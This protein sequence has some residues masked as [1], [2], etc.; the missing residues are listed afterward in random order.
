VSSNKTPVALFTYNRPAEAQ[1]VLQT[2]SKCARLDECRVFIYCD[3]PASAETR[4]RVEASRRV[5]R[6]WAGP[7]KAEVIERDE[8]LGLARS[9]VT[10]VTELCREMGRV[11]VVEDDFA[12][13]PDFL[14]YMLDGLAHYRDAPEVYQISGYMFPV[15][16]SALPELFFLPLTTTWGWATWER[17]WRI[18]DWDAT[19]ALSQLADPQLRRRFDLDESCPYSTMLEQRLKNRNDS[20]GIL[21]WWAVFKTGGL[22]LYPRRSLVW[23]GGF[24]GS[25]TH[26]RKEGGL[27]QDALEHFGEPRLSRPL[28]LPEAL[29]PCDEALERIKLFLRS[30]QTAPPRSMR[31]TLKRRLRRFLLGNISKDVA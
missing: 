16:Q 7:L 26:N 13:S 4:G 5:V 25:G 28:K 27:E 8:N 9:I 21:W 30:Q 15:A 19:D 20:W 22:V 3:G 17:A 24:D 23:V 12:L 2:L 10:G 6:E 29:V 31:A 1:L 14:D 11:I 18:F